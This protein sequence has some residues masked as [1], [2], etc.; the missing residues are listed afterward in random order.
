MSFT[1]QLGEAAKDFSLPAT[2]GQTYSLASFEGAEALV[3]FFTC[4]HCPYVLGSDELTR[5]TAERFMPKGV[6]FVGINAN[7]ATTKPED[8][9]EHMVARMSEHRFPWVYLRDETQEVAYAYGAL[10]TPHFFVFDRERK[11][12]Y[13]GRGVDNP[14]DAGRVT[15]SDLENALEDLLAGR[16]VRVPVTNPIGCNIKWEGRDAHWMPPEAC[17]LVL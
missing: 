9:F 4:N 15:V 10:R 8:S 3:V 1:L 6:A 12:V 5:K 11:L 17:D 14:K 16:P 7:S 2:D 13:T